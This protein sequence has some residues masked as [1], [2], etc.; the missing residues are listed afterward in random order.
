[1]LIHPWDAGDVEEAWSFVCAQGFGQLIAS[2]RDRDVPV[3]VATQYVLTG[4]ESQRQVLLH[5]ARPNP[6]WAAIAEN[7]R[8]VL[9]VAG[10]WAYLP[11][12]W[13]A[14]G[15]E[16]PA[17]GIPTTYYA[18]V[19]LVGDAAVLDDPDDV[20][21]VLRIQLDALEPGSGV[22]DPE[23]HTRR[24]AGIRALRIAVED[25][26]GKFKYGGN[27]DAEH[28]ASVAQRLATR[29]GPGDAAALAHLVRRSPE[30]PPP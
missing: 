30:L 29:G 20:L 9:A 1:M 16:D 17:L 24:L 2:G 4:G 11:S 5:L 18:A 22:A 27:V 14:V 13:K 21:H 15:D 10:D 6:I 19:Q 28:R 26:R 8:V 23:V 25:V 3:V 7:P 12:A